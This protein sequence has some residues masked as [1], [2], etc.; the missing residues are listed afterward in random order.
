[1]F[2][3]SPW[4]HLEAEWRIDFMRI[5]YLAMAQQS[6][7]IRLDQRGLGLSDRNPDDFTLDSC[8]LD[9]EAV[10]DRLG[11]EQL[12]VM[13]LGLSGIP[14]LAYT[15]RHPDR[16][17]HLVQFP[18][19]LTYDDLNNERIQKLT[20]LADVDWELASETIIRTLYSEFTDQQ[21]SDFTSLLRDA[22]EPDTF[23][24]FVADAQRWNV[25]VEAASMSTPTLLVHNLTNPNFDM[26]RTRRVA[27]LIKNS[28]VAFVDS[29]RESFP[30]A[31]K[32]FEEDFSDVAEPANIDATPP[33]P[34]TPI[35]VA[36]AASSRTPWQPGSEPQ[37][38]YVQTKDGVNIAYY[39]IGQGP[40]T[41]YLIMPQSHLE[42]EWRID[43]FRLAFTAYAQQNTFVRLDPRGCGLSDRDPDDFSI[44]SL[45]LDIE[46]VVDRLGVD[47]LRIYSIA[48]ATMPALAYTARHPDKVTHL[49]LQ[50][51]VTSGKDM[52][53]ERIDKLFELA[54]V[55]WG[56]ASETLVRTIMPEFT[57]Q[58]LSHDMAE[59]FTAA[60]EPTSL[61]RFVEEVREWDVEAEA[62][63]VSAPT[64]LIHTRDNPN[65]DMAT[66][67]RVAGSIKNSRVAFL[68]DAREG[69]LLAQR[70]FDED[71]ADVSEPASTHAATPPTATPVSVTP[72]AASGTPWQ[73]GSEPE[74]KYFETPDGVNIAY[75]EM[76]QGMPLIQL[77]GWPFCHLEAEWGMPTAR[78]TFE[79][80]AER[81]RLIRFDPRGSGMSQ[82]DVDDLSLDARVL[83]VETLIN[84]L[85]LDRVAL[86]AF[87]TAG[88]VA[89]AY[90]ARHPERVSHLMLGNSFARASDYVQSDRAQGLSGLITS[91]WE[92]FTETLAS[93][94][95][96]FS[97]GEY[98]RKFAA[99]MRACVTPEQGRRA[100]AAGAA[101]PHAIARSRMPPVISHPRLRNFIFMGSG[102]LLQNHPPAH[103]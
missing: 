21:V 61:L 28:R 50:P 100:L 9:I 99:Y 12:R 101:D 90:A 32:F 97:E 71:F 60:I 98:A 88:P 49:V 22:V 75:T 19:Q 57:D 30:L 72:P 35:S 76:G 83:D 51:P 66:T 40:A 24:R 15:A 2:L 86:F 27:G 96:G 25:E 26:D 54:K 102:T 68:D 44:D 13:T 41:L 79:R 3:T 80:V 73:P 78:L 94:F 70:F 55:D 63:A 62:K 93:V 29:A 16:V 92:L 8:V 39:A 46:A 17:T 52:S 87:G 81:L 64:L 47:S 42:V 23:S 58:Q 31:Q 67:R 103:P 45:V 7:L 65:F 37:I 91:D 48:Y 95:F 14:A 74:I 20:E 18:P 69:G 33:A 36:P 85:G 10:V 11:L 84:H 77:N 6:T 4:S 56:L 43:A 82:R 89:I 38:Q 5:G 34:A 59:L 1:M 53:N